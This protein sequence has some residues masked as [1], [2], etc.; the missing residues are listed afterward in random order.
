MQPLSGSATLMW[1]LSARSLYAQNFLTQGRIGS[2]NGIFTQSNGVY[3]ESGTSPKGSSLREL[4]HAVFDTLTQRRPNKVVRVGRGSL[5]YELIGQLVPS[6][7]VGWILG[8]RRV[9]RDEVAEAK[10]EESSVTWEKVER[11]SV[12]S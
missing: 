3:T 10:M 7:L 8:I 1:P 9:S 2:N 6:G 12:A 5:T 4:H 11:S